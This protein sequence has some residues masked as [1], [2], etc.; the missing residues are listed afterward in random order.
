[1]AST[2][3]RH[4][5][6]EVDGFIP[7]PSRRPRS[8]QEDY[9]SIGSLKDENSASGS[10]SASDS[11]DADDQ[12]ETILP[13]YHKRMRSFEELLQRNPS[14]V[15]T[16]LSLLSHSLSQVPATSKNHVK[17]RS[18]ITISVLG[19]A[20][21]NLPKGPSSIR[22]QLLYLH[23]GEEVWA[24]D[25]LRQEWEKALTAGDINV[26]LAWLDWRIRSGFDGQGGMLEAT[27]RVLTSATSELERLRV[28]W[29]LTCALRQAGMSFVPCSKHDMSDT[30]YRLH[31]TIYGAV[32]GPSRPVFL[33]TSHH[34]PSLMV[35][36][37]A[38][39]AFT[40]RQ[41]S[42][43]SHWRNR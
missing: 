29:R 15:S 38:A 25:K 21:P 11:G 42:A 13:S 31:R 20:M 26:F 30:T 24:G 5:Y 27:T 43:G 33:T 35:N 8:A 36:N 39:H 41:R 14:S 3:S 12:D 4:K 19:R 37:F 23:A 32:P 17:V 1:M 28:F 16:W 6:Q 2:S 40:A 34:V 18:E 22:I 7:L 10:S 9:R